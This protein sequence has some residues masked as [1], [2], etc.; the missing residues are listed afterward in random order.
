MVGLTENMRVCVF[1]MMKECTVIIHM[2][3]H[4]YRLP[5]DIRKSGGGQ[6]G[7]V[8]PYHDNTYTGIC[9][10]HG[11]VTQYL[12]LLEFIGAMG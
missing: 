8:I 4:V 9:I 2:Q 1:D 5:P 3:E 6:F 10:E 12:V 7:D 11:V